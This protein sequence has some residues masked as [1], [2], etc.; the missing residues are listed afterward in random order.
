MPAG[1]MSGVARGNPETPAQ[2]FIVAEGAVGAGY[3]S[4]AG[5]PLH[6]NSFANPALPE[7]YDAD[8]LRYYLNAFALAIC[9]VNVDV[10]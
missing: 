3:I 4:A 8:N 2:P 9:T 6:F 7:R 5:N 1:P 10:V